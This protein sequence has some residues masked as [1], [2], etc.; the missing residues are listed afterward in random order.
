[1][2]L[3]HQMFSLLRLVLQFTSQLGILNHRELRSADQLLFVQ[4]EHVDFDCADLQQHFFTQFFDF[5]HFFIFDLL[6]LGWVLVALRIQFAFPVVSFGFV[7]LDSLFELFQLFNAVF[8]TLDLR[9]QFSYFFS[10]FLFNGQQ[11]LLIRYRLFFILLYCFF[12]FNH[13]NIFLVS[14]A[15]SINYGLLLMSVFLFLLSNE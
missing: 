9:V 10:S 4:V 3:V 15:V 8:Q 14:L 13:H 1:M 7:L 11:L 2:I 12:M 6:D 5:L